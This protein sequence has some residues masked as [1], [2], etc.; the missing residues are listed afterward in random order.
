MEFGHRGTPKW[1]VYAVLHTVPSNPV[2]ARRKRHGLQPVFE[3]KEKGQGD[4]RTGHTPSH[5]EGRDRYRCH[6]LLPVVPSPRV[7]HVALQRLCVV[8]APFDL[9]QLRPLPP[10]LVAVLCP[11][12]APACN[13]LPV[14]QLFAGQRELRLAR[15]LCGRRCAAPAPALAAAVRRT[16]RLPLRLRLLLRR[17]SPHGPRRPTPLVVLRLRRRRCC[18]RGRRRRG[19]R[20][21]RRRRRGGGQVFGVD[22]G[23][24]VGGVA[25]LP[26]AAHEALCAGGGRLARTLRLTLLWRLRRCRCL[27]GRP[28]RLRLRRVFFRRCHRLPRRHH[29]RLRRFGCS[30]LLCR[31]RL[32]QARCRRRL[33]RRRV[34]A[35]ALPVAVA[36][37]QPVDQVRREAL[38]VPEAG[39]VVVVVA[40]SPRRVCGVEAGH[41]PFVSAAAAPS[42]KYR[43]CSF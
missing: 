33:L 20:L 5:V 10:S 40:S 34:G 38:V 1:H 36:A 9:A 17:R 35:C 15:P 26:A 29:R 11:H 3:G 39:V 22:G 12:A 19:C 13:K 14:R 4:V 37:G 7:L 30:S 18:P 23:V 24:V 28:W 21:R 25:V 27:R 41:V 42:M 32:Q 31:R 6:L 2:N 43:Y 16:L 8:V